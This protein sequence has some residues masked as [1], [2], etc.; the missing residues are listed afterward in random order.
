VKEEINI[1]FW[2]QNLKVQNYTASFFYSKI[3]HPPPPQWQEGLHTSLEL[4]VVSHILK[5][6]PLSEVME[7]QRR[8]THYVSSI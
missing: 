1:N 6:V 4:D 7:N 8:L 2:Q 3:M 5:T